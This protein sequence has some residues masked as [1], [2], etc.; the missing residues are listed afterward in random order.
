LPMR[1]GMTVTVSIDGIGSLENPY[2][3]SV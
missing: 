3:P 2:A 1:P